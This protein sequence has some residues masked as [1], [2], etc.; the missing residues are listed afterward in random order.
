VWL[1]A[2][3]A[4]IVVEV[5]LLVVFERCQVYNLRVAEKWNDDFKFWF[6]SFLVRVGVNDNGYI[7]GR[8]QIQVHTDEQTQVHSVQSS[9]VVT[10]LSTNRGRCALT[11]SELALVATA[12]PRFQMI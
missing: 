2:H 11:F 12:S 4:H 6:D 5:E 9:L 1:V 8:S 7:D 3:R 10:H